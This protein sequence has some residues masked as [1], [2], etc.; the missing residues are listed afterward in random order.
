MNT[1]NHKTMGPFYAKQIDT[2]NSLIVQLNAVEF[3]G[4]ANLLRVP[5]STKN[6]SGETIARE[7]QHIIED[8]IVAFGRCGRSQRKQIISALK[9]AVRSKNAEVGEQNGT[10]TQTQQAD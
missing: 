9:E 10:P 2:F 6:K 1:Q 5:L 7:A 8:T 4:L 3:L